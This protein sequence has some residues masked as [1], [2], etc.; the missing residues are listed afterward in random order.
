MISTIRP[1]QI[2]AGFIVAAVA[3]CAITRFMPAQ[4]LGASAGQVGQV[5]S[6]SAQSLDYEF[7]KTRVEPIF[8]KKR[9][10]H[11]RCY[12]CHQVQRGGAT[13]GAAPSYL[14]KVS[15]G[16]TFWTEDQSRLNFKRVS[17]FVVPGD[18]A[19]SPLLKH[20][21]AP[22]AGGDGPPVHGGGRQFESQSDPD[23]QTLAEW[24]R[25]NKGAWATP[26]GWLY[27]SETQLDGHGVAR[28]SYNLR[29]NVARQLRPH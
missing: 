7:F 3:P 20:P 5:A 29:H 15:P 18:T 23:W 19:S 14:E 21:L 4:S 22:E 2:V 9:A 6:A 8:L 28:L 24:V 26:L 12:V 25:G 27:E 17:Q 1:R 11:A 16:S 10:G 13:G